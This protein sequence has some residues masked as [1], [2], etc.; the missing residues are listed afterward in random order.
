MINMREKMA[1]SFVKKI[2]ASFFI[3]IFAL[4]FSVP[5]GFAQ[6]ISEKKAG[7]SEPCDGGDLSEAMLKTLNEIN[8]ELESLDQELHSLYSQALELYHRNA[9]PDSYK[10]LLAKINKVKDRRAE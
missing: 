9:M 3:A 1:Q 6:T 5:S 10:D 4:P 7:L 2:A 8:K